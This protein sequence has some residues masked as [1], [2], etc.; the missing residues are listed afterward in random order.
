[1]QRPTE[2]DTETSLGKALAILEAFSFERPEMSVRE[3]AQQSGVSRSTTHRLVLELLDWGALERGPGG[4][5][6][7][8][9]LFELGTLA[10]THATLREAASPFL[11]TLNEVTRLTANFAVREG[12]AIVYLEKIGSRTLKVPHSR[13]GGRGSLHATA[14]GKA[15]L[16]F[17]GPVSLEELLSEPLQ[18]LTPH[19]MTSRAELNAETRKVRKTSVAYDLEESREG[20]FCVASPVFDSR[21]LITAAVSVTGATGQSQAEHFAPTVHAIALGITRALR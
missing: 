3:L 10:P 2:Q 12:N 21:G 14:L 19:T 7:G 13:M 1:M 4:V 9:R 6:L 16:A 17:S 11:H 18:P 8:V 5:R 20:L 15:I